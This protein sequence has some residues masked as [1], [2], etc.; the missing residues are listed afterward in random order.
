MDLI[1]TDSNMVDIGVLMD[2]KLDL[3]FGKDENNLECTLTANSHCCDD[4]YYLHI[5]G[6]EYG[7]IIDSIEVDTAANKVIYFG[8]TWHGILGSKVI[9]PLLP[10]EA[11]GGGVTIK[12][13]DSS[14]ASLTNKYLV[15]SGD[16]NDCLGFILKRLGLG[17][18]FETISKTAGVTINQ[19]QFDRFTDGYSGLVKM[20]DSIG[21]RLV[22]E[23]QEGKVI[24]SSTD[25]YDFSTDEEFNS[26]I[27][28][29]RLKK[30]FKTV[31]HLVCLGSGELENRMIVHL[32]ADGEGNISQVQTQTGLLEYSAIYDF[33]AVE[34]EEELVAK[35][36]ERLLEL[37]E[38]D[39]MV[40]EL[41]DTS[42]F[43]NVGD[44]VG[45]SDEVTK[46][47][48]SGTINKKIVTIENGH[49][50]ISYK[51]GE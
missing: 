4:G 36:T 48:S 20:L 18:M 15:I 43:Y 31:N 49:I 40:I 35:G 21:R 14:G 41:D 37:W 16:V 32:Y 47:S 5:E 45:A 13:K 33:P 17:D 3:A 27:V 50:T 30:K 8:R 12:T 1:Y 23:Y 28:E 22:V 29:M 19:F 42:D 44:K 51:V 25:K 2:Y 46:L 39:N 6:T 11:S 26:D 24:I 38:P 34:S 7:G 10:G 9:A